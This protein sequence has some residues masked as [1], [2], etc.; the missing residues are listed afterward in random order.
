MA[1]TLAARFAGDEVAQSIQ[2]GIEY[3][4]LSVRRAGDG[5][6]AY[7]GADVAMASRTVRGT[8]RYVAATI[9]IKLAAAWGPARRRTWDGRHAEP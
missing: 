7:R 3:A 4:P 9:R 6:A 8:E 5:G 2:L 1:L